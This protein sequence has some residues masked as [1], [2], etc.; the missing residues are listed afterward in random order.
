MQVATADIA[1][2][3]SKL[4]SADSTT[5]NVSDAVKKMAR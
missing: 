5:V 1:E 2:R 3:R 4:L